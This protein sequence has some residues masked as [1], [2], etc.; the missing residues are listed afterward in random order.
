MAAEP[1]T[2]KSEHVYKVRTAPHRTSPRP[3]HTTPPP[4]HHTRPATTRSQIVNATFNITFN[5]T[6]QGKGGTVASSVYA[7]KA[8]TDVDVAA[9]AVAGS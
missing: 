6:T 8:L 5:S 3:P 9:V 7:F 1:E 4:T 2:H